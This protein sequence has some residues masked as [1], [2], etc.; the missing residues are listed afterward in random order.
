MI[1]AVLSRTEQT[2]DIGRSGKLEQRAKGGDSPDPGTHRMYGEYSITCFQKITSDMIHWRRRFIFCPYDGYA[3]S[4]GKQVAQLIIE[5]H[6]M[7]F[8][9]RQSAIVE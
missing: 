9:L 2:D 4:C 6:E 7:S 1:R 5:E 3:L 8:L